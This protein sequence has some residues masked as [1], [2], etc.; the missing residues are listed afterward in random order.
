RRACPA[1]TPR[2]APRRDDQTEPNRACTHLVS[3][4][5]LDNGLALPT[6]SAGRTILTRATLL[7]QGLHACACWRPSAV[8]N[9]YQFWLAAWVGNRCQFSF[10]R[11]EQPKSK[12]EL[13]R[14]VKGDTGEGLVASHQTGWTGLVANLID[15]WRR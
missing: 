9:R 3:G 12:V 11:L 2:A 10:G 1:Q 15:E 7:R 8:R 6:M 13:H 5:S 14:L 4:L